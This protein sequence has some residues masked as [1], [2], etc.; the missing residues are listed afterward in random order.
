ML[1]CGALT[2]CAVVCVVLLRAWGRD[3]SE[4]RGRG[5]QSTAPPNPQGRHV[6][7]AQGPQAPASHL[8]LFHRPSEDPRAP[9]LCAVYVSPSSRAG[10]RAAKGTKTPRPPARMENCTQRTPKTSS[11]K[12]LKLAGTSQHGK[13]TQKK[14]QKLQTARSSAENSQ[15]QEAEE[16][17]TRTSGAPRNDVLLDEVQIVSPDHKRTLD[18]HGD[19]LHLEDPLRRCPQPQDRTHLDNNTHSMAS[20]GVNRPRPT[21]LQ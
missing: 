19:A 5:R 2:V 1:W 17:R 9:P 4:S 18:L 20:S 3:A 15:E 12:S 16:G 10:S 7:T 21:Y 11:C 6:L 13:M 14:Q 8:P